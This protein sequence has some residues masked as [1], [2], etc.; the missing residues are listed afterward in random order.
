MSKAAELMQ[1]IALP[2]VARHSSQA[3]PAVRD[4][5]EVPFAMRPAAQAAGAEPGAARSVLGAQALNEH[6]FAEQ[7]KRM[8]EALWRFIEALLRAIARLFRIALGPSDASQGGGDKKQAA[9][10]ETEQAA[11]QRPDDGQAAQGA[12]FVA[13]EFVGQQE[14]SDA[15]KGE[16]FQTKGEAFQTKGEAFQTKGEFGQTK[17]E[18]FQTKGEFGQS[19]G[20]S[21]QSEG[22]FAAG[23]GDWIDV[24]ARVLSQSTELAPAGD[25][26]QAL[27]DLMAHALDVVAG[28]TEARLQAMRQAG[29]QDVAGVDAQALCR[30]V[31]DA[32]AR[33]LVEQRVAMAAQT[34]AACASLFERDPERSP[35]SWGE[36]LAAQPQRSAEDDAHLA[37]IA[38]LEQAAVLREVTRLAAA[39]A[40]LGAGAEWAE[41][42]RRWPEVSRVLPGGDEALDE[43]A[44]DGA[45]AR[46]AW[47]AAQRLETAQRWLREAGVDPSQSLREAADDLRRRAGDQAAADWMRSAQ[48]VRAALD[49]R[50][51]DSERD[52]KADDA[53]DGD[54]EEWDGGEW[55]GGERPQAA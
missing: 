25:P 48:H 37:A 46:A 43:R 5:Q 54:E 49:W 28:I 19:E 44:L 14:T 33:A 53:A 27:R 47:N 10:A 22:G 39:R 34:Q 9:Q 42:R 45:L 16:A 40:L 2:Q 30:E 1:R 15:K 7:L 18:A 8:A 31:A 20:A 35:S 32:L 13:Q 4:A 52:G 36:T 55:D 12:G 51:Q 41:V 6:E 38:R 3:L 50:P 21:F 26:A 23:K 11:Q 17:G 24:T 29:L